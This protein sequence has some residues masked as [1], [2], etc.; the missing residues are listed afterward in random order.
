MIYLS[1]NNLQRIYLSYWDCDGEIMIDE[2]TQAIVTA[3]TDLV[4]KAMIVSAGIIGAGLSIFAGKWLVT[5]IKNFFTTVTDGGNGGG[6]DSNY[7]F[8]D[9][10]GYYD[11]DG[12]FYSFHY[13][14][15]FSSYDEYISIR[16]YDN[17]HP[18]EY[19]DDDYDADYDYDIDG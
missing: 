19:D 6:G 16:I 2:M 14:D 11:D 4:Y 15:W 10:N 13:D 1:Y 8:D 5:T 18:D 9:N 7:D 17:E 3:L 12:H